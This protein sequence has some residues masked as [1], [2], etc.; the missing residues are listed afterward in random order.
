MQTQ[1]SIATANS[2][3]YRRGVTLTDVLKSLMIMAIGVT[4][5][6]TLFTI[7]TL[8][9]AQATSLTN[10]ELLKYNTK[11]LFESRP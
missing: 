1:K 3:M 4:S 9:S 10:S 8:R 5:V 7:A 6:M 11:A 2:S